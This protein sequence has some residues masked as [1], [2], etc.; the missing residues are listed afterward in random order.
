MSILYRAESRLTLAQLVPAWAKELVDG[1]TSAREV[2]RD[3]WRYLCED[4]INGLLDDAG[5]LRNGRRWGLA[6]IGPDDRA[7][8]V[9]GRVLGRQLI[10]EGKTRSPFFSLP[11]RILV[12]KEA[13]ARFCPTARPA[14]TIVV[15]RYDQRLEKGGTRYAFGHQVPCP[16]AGPK[17]D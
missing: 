11:D 6:I 5:P 13:V 7:Q 15:G 8:Y 9:E 16:E 1:D 2:E 10:R 14:T 3:L 4:T 12:L 17:A